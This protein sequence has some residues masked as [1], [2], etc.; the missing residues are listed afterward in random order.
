MGLIVISR[1]FHKKS[2]CLKILLDGQ[3]S[4]EALFAQFAPA[5][6]RDELHK[7]HQNPERM[8]RALKRFIGALSSPLPITNFIEILKPNR[9]S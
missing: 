3:P 1:P 5:T 9:I 6:V 8:P 4:L 7:A 2:R